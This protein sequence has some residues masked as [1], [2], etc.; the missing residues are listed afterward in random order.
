MRYMIMYKPDKPETGPPPSEEY[1]AE[2]EKLVAEQMR[3][4]PLLAGE[5]FQPTATGA[6]VRLSKGKLT[7]TDGPFAETKELIATG[8]GILQLKS[9]EE[10]IESAKGFLETAG[11]G[12]CEIRLLFE[13]SDAPAIR[14]KITPCLWFDDQAE[15]AANF[16]TAIF[17]NSKIT[18][19]TRYGEATVEVSGKRQGTVMTVTFQLE[20]QEFMALNGGPQFTFSPAISLIVNC[21]TQP[22]VDELWQRLSAGGQTDRCGWLKDKFGVSWQIV[23][24]VIA[25]MLQDQDTKKSERVMKAL[26]QMEKLDIET[27]KRAYEDRVSK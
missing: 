1:L 15:E 12:E 3:T 5:R 26:L 19:R 25:R 21:Q 24:A 9:K 7:V 17:K 6:R 20:G 4:G 27:L 11:E 8:F 23:P 10:A 22:E 16:Y 14:Q 13:P 18:S 2:M